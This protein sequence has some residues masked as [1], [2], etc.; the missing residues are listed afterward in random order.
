[1]SSLARARERVRLLEQALALTP[2]RDEPLP[3]PQSFARRL[4]QRRA[5]LEALE[6]P[7]IEP[8]CQALRREAAS[9]AAQ[10]LERDAA[11]VERLTQMRDRVG[12][13]LHRLAPAQRTTTV[14]R[15][16]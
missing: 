2:D 14:E 8:E 3:D 9:L 13:L 16:A 5:Y 11:I 12:R 6:P 10:I 4:E 1:M 15:T 7:P